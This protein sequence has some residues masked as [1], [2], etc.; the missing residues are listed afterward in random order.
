M[1]TQEELVAF[2]VE[3]PTHP[4]VRK[5]A[6]DALQRLKYSF[7]TA[8]AQQD[9]PFAFPTRRNSARPSCWPSEP[10]AVYRDRA[11]T[12][13]STPSPARE[14]LYGRYGVLSLERRTGRLGFAGASSKVPPRSFNQSGLVAALKGVQADRKRSV[15]RL[16]WTSRSRSSS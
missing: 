12:V 3:A 1:P 10:R 14:A 15:R 4:E 5:I 2:H 9:Q 16:N 13:A 6:E 7:L 11:L 8:A